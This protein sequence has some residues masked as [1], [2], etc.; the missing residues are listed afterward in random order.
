MRGG[1]NKGG[2]LQLKDNSKRAIN[3]ALTQI[4]FLQT[5]NIFIITNSTS[6]WFPWNRFS[7]VIGFK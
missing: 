5:P 7:S 4:F 1:E 6:N 3:L 2:K